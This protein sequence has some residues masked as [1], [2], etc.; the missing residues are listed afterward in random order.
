MN[1]DTPRDWNI[2]ETYV[3]DHEMSE[4]GYCLNKMC[5]SL[6][7][8][9]N[10]AAFKADENAYME[11]YRLT[12]EQKQAVRNRDWLRMVKLGGNIYL[13]MKIGAVVG[14]G[15]YTLGAQQRGQTLEQF[16]ETRKVPGAT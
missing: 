11:E 15:L 6:T 14:Q 7:K 4:K 10:R 9:E 8:P 2:P 5:M 13:L 12:E 3:F 1:A 16:L